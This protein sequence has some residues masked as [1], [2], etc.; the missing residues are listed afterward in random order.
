MA[1]Q[2]EGK[3]REAQEIYFEYNLKIQ[4]KNKNLKKQILTTL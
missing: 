1:K 2:R 4:R 3:R